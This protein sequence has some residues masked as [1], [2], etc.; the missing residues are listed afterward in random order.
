MDDLK[1]IIDSLG[2]QNEEI[3]D[4]ELADI[5]EE[6]D[7]IDVEE[8]FKLAKKTIE[9]GKPQILEYL[10]LCAAPVRHYSFNQEEIKKLCDEIEKY[11]RIQKKLA[12]DSDDE[13]DINEIMEEYEQIIKKW[14]KLPYIS[15]TR[16]TRTT[17]TRKR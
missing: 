16:T 17:H 12:D 14:R 4:Y 8:Y 7:S 1:F 10:V 9:L 5:K 13:E 3:E 2:E 6:I 15:T 11:E